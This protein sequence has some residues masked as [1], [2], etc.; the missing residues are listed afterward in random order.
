[1]NNRTRQYYAKALNYQNK[2]NDNMN[3]A[4]NSLLLEK[5]I[6]EDFADRFDISLLH[7]GEDS[8]T[9]DGENFIQGLNLNRLD[10]MTKEQIYNLNP[11]KSY[12]HLIN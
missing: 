1:M 7:G 9:M 12:I 3:L 5:G 6:S 10:G 4:L 11:N 8:I 2:V